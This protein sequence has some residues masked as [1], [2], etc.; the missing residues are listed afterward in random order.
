MAKI[1]FDFLGSPY[2]FLKKHYCMLDLLH[3]HDM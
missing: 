2:C 1:D 3:N